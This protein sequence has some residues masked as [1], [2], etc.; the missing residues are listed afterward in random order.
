MANKEKS[1]NKFF[2]WVW[3]KEIVDL[4]FLKLYFLIIFVISQYNTVT[5]E[6]SENVEQK[7]IEEY[8]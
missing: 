5:G 6:L 8:V 7:F 3:L 1:F 2:I 4:F